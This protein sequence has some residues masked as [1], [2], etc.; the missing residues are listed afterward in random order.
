MVVTYS[1]SENAGRDHT[2]YLNAADQ[3]YLSE[4][5]SVPGT[6][7]EHLAFY[8]SHKPTM[9]SILTEVKER[10]ILSAGIELQ[11]NDR[12]TASLRRPF[13]KGARQPGGS[14]RSDEVHVGG[15]NGFGELFLRVTS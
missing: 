15:I 12:V 13:K 1:E 3:R 2:Q 10:D 4:H 14:S 8:Y 9:E 11:E 6:N 5:R 7:E